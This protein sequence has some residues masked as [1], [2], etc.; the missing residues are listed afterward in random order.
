MNNNLWL[1]NIT[2]TLAFNRHRTLFVIRGD[3]DYHKTWLDLIFNHY[4]KLDSDIKTLEVVNEIN[5]SLFKQVLKNKLP[6]ML[7]EEVD[8]VIFHS[9]YGL[10]PNNLAQASGMVKAGGMCIILLDN[11]WLSTPNLAMKKYLSYPLNLDEGLNGHRLFLNKKLLQNAINIQQGKKLPEVYFSEIKKESIAISLNRLTPTSEQLT[12][13]NA[14]NSVGFGHRN[15]PLLLTADR[16]RGKSSALGFAAIELLKAGKKHIAI[17]A[18]RPSQVVQLLKQAFEYAEDISDITLLEKMPG[19]GRFKVL[20]SSKNI[21]EIARIQF[22]AVDE[23]VQMKK[24]FD[25][26]LVDEAAQLPLSLLEKLAN[27]YSRVVFT[28]TETGYEG[29][30]MGFKLLFSKILAKFSY[31]KLKLIEPIRWD[32]NDPLE[33]AINK[34]LLLDEAKIADEM[35]ALKKVERKHLS[36]K[37]VY[38]NELI[39]QPDLIEQIFSLLTNAHY[40]TSPD[41]LMQLLEDPNLILWVAFE[42]YYP[43]GVLIAFKEGG[44]DNVQVEKRYQGHLVAQLLKRQCLD[45]FWLNHQSYR[46]NRIAVQVD[47]QGKGIGTTLVNHFISSVQKNSAL[48]YVS[49]SFSARERLISFWKKQGFIPAYLGIKKDKSSA[50][51]SLIMLYGLNE[52][53][54]KKVEHVTSQYSAQF[55]YLLQSTFKALD[56][57]VVLTVLESLS[58]DDFKFPTAYLKEQEFETVSYSLLKWSLANPSK[59]DDFSEGLKEIWVKKILQ[60][61]SWVELVKKHG[62]VSRK[63]VETEFRY[64]LMTFIM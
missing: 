45:L 14:I 39:E 35:V 30:G 42:E 7:G 61:Y 50:T 56:Y 25:V 24:Q 21:E 27:T 18:S 49:V 57:R 38:L 53:V 52:M 63:Q 44:I 1:K 33:K 43:V 6:Q 13:I 10:S 5:S 28:S 8:L 15:R 32:R 51:H 60:N 9:K 19:G 4:I 62:K 12:V 59:I 64:L 37:K 23:L 48:D 34:C 47:L 20:D 17:T 26:L 16:G 58:Y 40:Q 2:T 41:S 22:Y 55:S 54:Q 29:S 31:K 11:D 36:Y 46:I 3:A